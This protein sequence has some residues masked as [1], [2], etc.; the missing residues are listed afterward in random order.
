M[1]ANKATWVLD[2]AS[3]ALAPVWAFGV[4]I[5]LARAHNSETLTEPIAFAA[6][7]LFE[8]LNQPLIHIV[9]GTEHIQ[10]VIN[11][12]R[13]IQE[14]LTD[15][16][17]EDHRLLPPKRS[18]SREIYTQRSTEDEMPLK[19]DKTS[20]PMV[21]LNMA[22][23]T[24]ATLEDVSAGY[25]PNS[26]NIIK[27][28][29]FEISRGKTTM[30][31]GPVGSGKSTILRLLLGEVQ[32]S[33][34][35]VSTCFSRAAFCPQSP[36]ITWGSIQENILGMS[37]WGKPWYDTVASACALST[38][39]KELPLGDQTQTGTRGSRLSGGQQMRV[40]SYSTYSRVKS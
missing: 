28:L 19:E 11:S 15:E 34:G 24:A 3:S 12:F 14:Y 16:E 4:Y 1:L 38:D 10:T 26:Q 2:F 29:N 27:N 33:E 36:W 37:A 31:Y 25:P 23:K 9:D 39:F 35:S 18:S 40:V 13:R 30:I 5:L 8:L 6:L 32:A 20:I 7:S 22:T 21:S 17:R